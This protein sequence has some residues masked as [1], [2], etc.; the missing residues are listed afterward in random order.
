VKSFD[1]TMKAIPTIYSGVRFRSRLEAK[2][3]AFFDRIG[4]P[5]EYEPFDL[6]GWAP[7]FLL[8]FPEPV[9]RGGGRALLVG[10]SLDDRE[11]HHRTLFVGVGLGRG[12]CGEEG[13]ENP[14]GEL[15]ALGACNC[16]VGLCPSLGA[17]SC[18]RCGYYD[19]NALNGMCD[20]IERAWADASNATQWRRR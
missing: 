4:W 14:E 17:Y 6:E 3:A 20:T 7:D 15:I 19:G 1:Y 5:W 10:A 13:E 9:L 11:I 12:V 18:W 2:W 16:G 8:R